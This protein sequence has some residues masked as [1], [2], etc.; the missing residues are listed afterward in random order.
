M[1]LKPSIRNP[2]N[3][4][5]LGVSPRLTDSDEIKQ[6]VEK[7]VREKLALLSKVPVN[8]KSAPL[9]KKL[10]HKIAIAQKILSDP[11]LRHAYKVELKSKLDAAKSAK[12][13]R[14]KPAPAPPVPNSEM[15]PP[16][17]KPASASASA[18]TPNE[19]APPT[20][21]SN[22]GPMDQ[23]D[24]TPIE[25]PPAAKP[26]IANPVV[27]NPVT[28]GTPIVG[29]PP[30][31]A[32]AAAPILNPDMA[33]PATPAAAT[34]A[35]S[36]PVQAAIPMA[37]PM[38]AEQAPP[39]VAV[40]LQQTQDE[41]ESVQISKRTGR[42]KRSKL[43]APIALLT[44][45]GVMGG[46]GYLIYDNFD[47]LL[48]LGKVDPENAKIGPGVTESA[49]DGKAKEEVPEK[50]KAVD[51]DSMSEL[52]VDEIFNKDDEVNGLEPGSSKAVVDAM[53]QRDQAMGKENPG[54]GTSNE[55]PGVENSTAPPKELKSLDDSQVATLRRKLE[56]AHRSLFRRDFANVEPL[57]EFSAQMADQSGLAADDLVPEHKPLVY[58]I[59][60]TG[61]IAVLVQGFW[62]Q[63]HDSAE[64]I[65]G[66]QEI[67]IGSQIVG[68]VESKPT[69]VIVRR[70]GG[71][72]EY[73]YSWCPPGLALAIAEQGAVKDVPTW[74]MQ[75]A[76]FFSVDQLSGND[77]LDRIDEFLAIA[78][79]ANHDCEAIRRFSKFSFGKLGVP[80]EKVEF[81][82]Q[83]EI[84]P[85]VQQ[86]RDEMGYDRVDKV[87]QGKAIEHAKLLLQIDSPN[88]DQHVSILEEARQLAIQGGSASLA[89]D[90]LLDLN[91]FANFDL[92]ML[93]HKTYS[94]LCDGRRT[95][96][97]IRDLMERAIPYLNSELGDRLDSKKKTRLAKE[98]AELAEKFNMRDAYRRLSQIEIN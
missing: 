73:D 45:L 58:N 92:T 70:A 14:P 52:D 98:L 6:A 62:K 71:N 12:S 55:I 34:Q 81:P 28:A 78:E 1:G 95:A 7:G 44:M 76:A 25:D 31:E 13:A 88:F 9:I 38:G 48:K 51:L 3:F 68:F 4:Q 84:D 69:S 39:A 32:P 27:A 97:Q 89:E 18:P 80:Q 50:L 72:I 96:P 47:A 29:P 33:A 64:G 19:L 26:I 75:K 10:K 17:A 91:N 35:A 11:K 40:P 16:T 83:D 57:L 30:T 94:D 74:N 59:A 22:S 42:K 23:P 36:A 60:D 65:S 46:G 24:F 90:A 8:E 56:H 87:D 5:L 15:L 21:S 20:R 37:V 63:V 77:H 67:V 54:S 49:T 53:A 85:A 79:S 61:K 41:I 2:H 66:A 82:E 86:F 43:V 93:S